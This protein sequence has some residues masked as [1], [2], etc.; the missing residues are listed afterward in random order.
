GYGRLVVVS[1]RYGMRSFYAHLKRVT[2]RED[3]RVARGTRIGLVGSSGHSTGPHLHFEL[4][5]RGAAVDPLP[6][7]R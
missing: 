2:V 6:A 7:L 3:Q 1:H 4:R 5:R